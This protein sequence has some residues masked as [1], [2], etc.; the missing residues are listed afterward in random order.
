MCRETKERAEVCRPHVTR[1]TRNESI[2]S[3]RV[4]EWICSADG[5]CNTALEYYHH[6]CRSMI[7]GRKCNNKCKNSINI[8]R[9]QEKATKLTTCVCDGREEYDCEQ[10]RANMER[11]CYNREPTPTTT[12][13]PPHL[14]EKTPSTGS[15]LL[16]T[17]GTTLLLLLRWL[18]T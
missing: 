3:C 10:I 16:P 14:S 1:A 5:V 13:P 18:P 2:V 11:L 9:R 4:A 12:R 6:N 15:T 7:H 17:M 8:L